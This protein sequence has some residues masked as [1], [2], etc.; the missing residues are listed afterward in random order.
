MVLLDE[1]GLLSAVR[2]SPIIYLPY[3][4]AFKTR[5]A[6]VVATGEMA[7]LVMVSLA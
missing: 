7:I 6:A 2:N 5:R 4:P 3:G 1:V